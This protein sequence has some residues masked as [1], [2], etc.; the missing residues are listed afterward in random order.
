MAK[1][2]NE[3][4]PTENLT[5]EQAIETLGGIVQKIE[6]GQV[7]LQESLT[8]YEQGMNLI[9]H[10]RK[11]LLDAEKRIEQ[12]HETQQSATPKAEPEDDEADEDVDNKEVNDAE[13]ESLF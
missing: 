7:P 4:N 3:K 11:I 6:T 1:K 9:Q 5:F 10:C 12:I 2:Q 8:Q 13:D